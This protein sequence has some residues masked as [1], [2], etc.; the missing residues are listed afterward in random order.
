MW[1]H[2]D[3]HIVTINVYIK[4]NA[5]CTK[6][7]GLHGNALKILLAS[8]PIDGRANKELLK[9][10]ATLF[11]VIKSQVKIKNGEKSRHKII[12]ITGSKINPQTICPFE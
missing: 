4:P 10:I 6:I 1:Y 7:A 9:Y 12:S 8:P 5:K 11:D 2:C 3:N